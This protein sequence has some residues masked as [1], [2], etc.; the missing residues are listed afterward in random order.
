MKDQIHPLSKSDDT[1]KANF[2]TAL[3]SATS[4]LKKTTPKE[5]TLSSSQDQLLAALKNRQSQLKKVPQVRG[6]ATNAK[7]L[8]FM[9]EVLCWLI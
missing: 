3:K 2:L 8:M 4:N 6:E 1:E 9:S 5:E 7:R